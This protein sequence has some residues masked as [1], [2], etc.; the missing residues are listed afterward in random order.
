MFSSI[1]PSMFLII[2]FLLAC[3]EEYVMR[4]FVMRKFIDVY[5][6]ALCL[7]RASLALEKKY[8]L[9]NICTI[10][11]QNIPVQVFVCVSMS[12]K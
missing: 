7:L 8:I 5:G 9:Y 11:V 12:Y 4:Y 2:F 6:I 10:H 3:I 1:S